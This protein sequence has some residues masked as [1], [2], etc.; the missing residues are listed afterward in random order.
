MPLVAGSQSNKEKK[1][2]KSYLYNET[3]EKA[4]KKAYIILG[5]GIWGEANR[6]DRCWRMAKD[7][8]CDG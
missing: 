5:W 8:S 6:K 3:I 2:D 1:S 4:K 7:A